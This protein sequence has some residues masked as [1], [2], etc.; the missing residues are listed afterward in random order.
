MRERLRDLGLFSLE[1]G[2]LRGD[3][4]NTYRYLKDGCQEDG[5]RLFSVVANDRT[6]AQVGTQE[7]PPQY[8]EKLLSCEGD[9]AVEQAAQGGVESPS[10]E[11]FKTCLDAVPCPLL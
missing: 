6:R 10:L 1:K 9:R 11:S 8:E 4:I 7:V 2:R 5:A 3:L